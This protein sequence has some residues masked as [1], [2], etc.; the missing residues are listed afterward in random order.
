M[1]SCSFK[2]Y[3]IGEPSKLERK[4]EEPKEMASAGKQGLSR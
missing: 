3:D 1:E 4:A 2:N